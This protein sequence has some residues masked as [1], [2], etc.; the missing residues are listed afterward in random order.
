MGFVVFV[1]AAA[2]VVRWAQGRFG[3]QGI[4]LLLFIMGALDVDASIVTAGG[5]PPATIGAD[6]AAIALAGTIIANMIVKMAVTLSYAR[7]DGFVATSALLA[8]T[9][10]LAA[11]I[12]VAWMNL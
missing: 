5:L 3:D 2:V 7:R 12:M 10:V 9:L 4:A 6:L 8:S 11:A 1:A